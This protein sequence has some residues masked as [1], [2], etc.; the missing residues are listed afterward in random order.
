MGATNLRHNSSSLIAVT[1]V[2]LISVAGHMAQNASP[3]EFTHDHTELRPG[4][5]P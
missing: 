5:H 2:A 3:E 1:G 4:R